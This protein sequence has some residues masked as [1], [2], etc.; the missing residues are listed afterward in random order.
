MVVKKTK[1]YTVNMWRLLKI[2]KKPKQKEYFHVAK[3][4]GISILIM[5]ALMSTVRLIIDLMT[6]FIKKIFKG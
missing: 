1:E 3:V 6:L 5:G 2:I 4:C